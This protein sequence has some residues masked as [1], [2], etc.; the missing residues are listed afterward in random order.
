MY[1]VVELTL[2]LATSQ[3]EM[4]VGLYLLCFSLH[5]IVDVFANGFLLKLLSDKV[6]NMAI[7]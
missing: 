6:I 7:W 4:L 5:C 2:K 3:I 1:N